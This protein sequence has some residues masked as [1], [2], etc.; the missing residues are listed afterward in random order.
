MFDTLNAP[1]RDAY[2]TGEESQKGCPF[3]HI[4]QNPSMD[5]KH[6]VLFRSS[7]YFI[8]MNRYPYTPGHFMIIP[9]LHTDNIAQLDAQLWQQ[10]MHQARQGVALLKEVMHIHGA[11]IGINIGQAGGAGIAEHLHIHVVP[12]WERDTNFMTSI[13]HTRVYSTDFEALHGRLLAQAG[14]FFE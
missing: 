6:H 11:N 13:A 1:W 10:M 9:H 4:V 12:R 8:V 3:C 2:V 7:D 14:R 5:A